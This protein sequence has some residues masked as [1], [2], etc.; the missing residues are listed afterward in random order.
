M[1][2]KVDKTLRLILLDRDGVINEDSP[3]F[4]RSAA[5]WLPIPG[6]IDAITLLQKHFSVAVCTNQSGIGRGYFDAGT[7]HQM[8]QKMNDLIKAAGGQ[9]VDVF[10]CPHHPDAGC[11]CRKPE[12]GLLRTAMAAQNHKAAHTLYVGDSEKDLLAADA[13]GCH[14]GLVLTGKGKQTHATAVG[15]ACKRVEPDLM[16]LARTLTR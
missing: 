11:D 13:A 16:A 2:L 4:I 15:Q 6:A 7:L 3:D 12:P 1:A 8:H 10:F 9:P 14:A 5:Q